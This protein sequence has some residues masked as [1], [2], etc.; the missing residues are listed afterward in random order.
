MFT[1]FLLN[2]ITSILG[3]FIGLLPEMSVL[4]TGF[5]DA[6]NWITD[7]VANFI[8]LLPASATILNIL[9]I[10]FTVELAILTFM[11]FNWIINKLRG[12]GN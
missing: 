6:W 2:L 11:L 7:W 12:S 9:S 8:Y 3:F 10:M 4:G 1:N 5:N